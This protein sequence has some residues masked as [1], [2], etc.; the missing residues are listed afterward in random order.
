[1]CDELIKAA[2]KRARAAKFQKAHSQVLAAQVSANSIQKKDGTHA[3]GE[4]VQNDVI[5]MQSIIVSLLAEDR[6]EALV[7]QAIIHEENAKAK[8]IKK[9][10]DA[11][12]RTLAGFIGSQS[13]KLPLVYIVIGALAGEKVFDMAIKL[14]FKS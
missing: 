1:M 8:S 11:Q 7:D 14:L 6:A 2:H 9:E 3:I 5:R 10:K 13:D 12:K 4:C